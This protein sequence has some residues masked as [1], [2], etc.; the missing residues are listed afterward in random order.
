MTATPADALH[1]LLDRACRGVAGPAEAEQLRA[2]VTQL[3]EQVEQARRTTGGLQSRVQQ[4]GTQLAAFHDGEEPY[5]DDRIVP[6]PGQWIWRWNR[7][8]PQQRLEIAAYVRAAIDTA[9]HCR[10]YHPELQDTMGW[11]R[12]QI[13]RY[14]AAWQSARRRARANAAQAAAATPTTIWSGPWTP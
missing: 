10:I 2:A 13:A 5:D 12:G 1:V 11:Q 8:T 14:Q 9:T 6:T 7:A 4:L 3:Q